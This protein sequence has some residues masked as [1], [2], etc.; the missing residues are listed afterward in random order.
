MKKQ[1]TKK[2]KNT[3]I[4]F[5]KIIKTISLFHFVPIMYD[6]FTKIKERKLFH[7]TK[8]N[9][10]IYEKETLFSVVSIYNCRINTNYI[11]KKNEKNTISP[12]SG[13]SGSQ[14]SL[15]NLYNIH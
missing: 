1:F 5:P 2:E 14:E 8:H 13:L 15:S 10:Q 11:K 7:L 6:D 3:K 4:H 12:I 9:S